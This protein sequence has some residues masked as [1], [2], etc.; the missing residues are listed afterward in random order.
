MNWRNGTPAPHSPLPRCR[1]ESGPGT[2][3]IVGGNVSIATTDAGV[4]VVTYT[5]TNTEG[6]VA[7]DKIRL[8]VN[9]VPQSEPPRGSRRRDDRLQWWIQQR[10]SAGKRHRDLGPGRRGRRSPEEQAADSPSEVSRSPTACLAFVAAPQAAGFRRADVLLTDGTGSD[11]GEVIITVQQCSE[12]PPSARNGTAFT[13]YMTPINVDLT[14]LVDSGNIVAGSVSGAG[15]TGPTGVY[16]PPAN[17]NGTETVTFT[18]ANGCR[19]THRGPAGH[20]RQPH[21]RSR[22]QRE[23]FDICRRST[24]V[25]DGR[26]PGLRR[27]GA[28]DRRP[29]PAT[30][31]GSHAD[32][33]TIRIRSTHLRRRRRVHVH[34]HRSGSGQL[35]GYRGDQRDRH[36]PAPRSRTPTPTRLLSQQLRLQ[37]ARRTT[38]IPRAVDC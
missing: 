19:Q 10:R 35:D 24:N 32:G 30:R 15:L 9:P 8:T 33:S 4:V 38:S 6:G 7:S 11:E 22:R 16:T 5:V 31:V 17:M 20:R 21:A 25:V 26:R 27:R 1:T 37:S 2:A 29:A 34:R 14:E 18:V 23:R 3:Q 28:D 36:Q 13:P 12:S